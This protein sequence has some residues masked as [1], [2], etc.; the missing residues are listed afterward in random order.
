MDYKVPPHNL[1]VEQSI[2]SSILFNQDVIGDVMGIIKPS[3]FYDEKHKIIFDAMIKMYQDDISIDL[4]TVSEFLKAK[5]SDVGGITYIT[6]LFNSAVPVNIKEYALIAKENSNRREIAKIGMKLY[7]EAFDNTHNSK[8]IL[9]AAEDKLISISG[10][11]ISE[12]VT[13]YNALTGALDQI[14]KNYKNG[15]RITGISTG[16]TKIDNKINGLNRGDFIIIAA[17]PSMGK[18]ALAVNIGTHVSK[19]HN[20]LLFSLETVKEKLINRILSSEAVIR[21]EKIR[22]GDLEDNDF[23]K[24]TKA[25]GKISTRKL[26]IDDNSGITVSEIKAK[27]K[28]TKMKMGLDL[29]VIDYLG[30]IESS[31]KYENRQLELSKMSRQLKNM[32]KELDTT[33]IALSQLNR[34]PELRQDKRPQLSDL[35]E[36]GGIEQDADIVMFLYRDD[37]Y[38]SDSDKK[39]IAECI[40]AK[41]RDGEVG[42]VEL[43]WLGEYQKFGDI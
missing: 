20:V 42:T 12:P 31:D 29:I 4:M 37:Y 1:E 25:A 40:I 19:T 2:L 26:I 7:A 32:A 16:F 11:K 24:L 21:H 27:A 30:I 34:N 33:V 14:E 6:Q 39:G 17:R 36:S 41:N 3:D 43:G 35:R 23:L 9:T 10:G 15:G 28:K 22:K 38:H 5:L 13:I 18:T 8:E